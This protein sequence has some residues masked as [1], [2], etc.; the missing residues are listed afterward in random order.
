MSDE[1]FGNCLKGGE[2]DGSRSR[3]K[4]ANFS[5][6]MSHDGRVGGIH[7][8]SSSMTDCETYLLLVSA[9]LS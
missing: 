6:S 2:N 8:D 9:G 3:Y 7:Q 4:S 1:L 5:R